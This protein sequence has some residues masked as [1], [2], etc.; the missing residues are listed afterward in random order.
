MA[1]H[2]RNELPH[3]LR[4]CALLLAMTGAPG[5]ARRYF[6]DSLQVAEAQ[7]AVY[8]H[9][10]TLLARGQVGLELHWPHE[11]WAVAP[12]SHTPC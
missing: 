9:A 6:D 1:R 11:R 3:V 7:G 8:E 12:H 4:E 5:K 10:Q 2:F